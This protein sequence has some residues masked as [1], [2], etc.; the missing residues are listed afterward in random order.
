MVRKRYGDSRVSERNKGANK[1][2]VIPP[3]G[4]ISYYI[5][6]ARQPKLPGLMIS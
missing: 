2:I 4:G 1:K 6:K 3:T 5:K